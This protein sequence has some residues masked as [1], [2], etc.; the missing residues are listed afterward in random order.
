MD[1]QEISSWTWEV[2]VSFDLTII[3][4]FKHRHVGE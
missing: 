3:P 2:L 4:F 1:T